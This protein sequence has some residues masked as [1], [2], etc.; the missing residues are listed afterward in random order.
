MAEV[1]FM[2]KIERFI[3]GSL[4]SNGYIVYEHQGGKCFIIDPGYEGEKF[5]K[6]ISEIFRFHLY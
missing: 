5:L 4:K 2:I 3:G 1:K 6:R